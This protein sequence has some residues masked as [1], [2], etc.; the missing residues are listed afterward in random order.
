MSDSQP[1]S[2]TLPAFLRPEAKTSKASYQNKAFEN[3]NRQ[4]VDRLKE[5]Y[6]KAGSRFS[7]HAANQG[8]N[9]N[10]NRCMFVAHPLILSH[11]HTLS[12]SLS[13]FLTHSLFFF[14]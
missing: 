4:E 3:L 5:G 8:S 11:S 2:A 12:L 7:I 6:E 14:S 9:R 1:Q 10:L 13:L